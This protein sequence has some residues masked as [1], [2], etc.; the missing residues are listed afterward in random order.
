MLKQKKKKSVQRSCPYAFP[1][2]T[3][4]EWFIRLP[5]YISAALCSLKQASG[6]VPLWFCQPWHCLDMWKDF[7]LLS[8]PW[9]TEVLAV[10]KGFVNVLVYE[11]CSS[12]DWNRYQDQVSEAEW[13]KLSFHFSIMLIPLSEQV[14]TLV[15]ININRTNNTYCHVIFHK[16]DSII[17]RRGHNRHKCGHTKWQ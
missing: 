7:M 9:P 5:G 3:I 13:E 4:F 15:L 11:G 14:K 12:R 2:G 1:A 10:V 17:E 8:Q 6:Y 16:Y